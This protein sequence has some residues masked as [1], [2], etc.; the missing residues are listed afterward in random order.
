VRVLDKPT[1][2]RFQTAILNQL[3][4]KGMPVTFAPGSIKRDYIWM[5]EHRDGAGLEL[6]TFHRFF[7]PKDCSRADPLHHDRIQASLT[8]TIN[9]SHAATANLSREFVVDDALALQAKSRRPIG[10][11]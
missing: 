9:G 10:G 4:A 5:I 7:I 11:V 8:R 2:Q 3:W 1:A 6:K